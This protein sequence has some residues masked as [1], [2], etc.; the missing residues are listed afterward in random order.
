M[1]NNLIFKNQIN[2]KTDIDFYDKIKIILVILCI[3][4]IPTKDHWFR[5]YMLVNTIL[6]CLLLVKRSQIANIKQFK[7][8]IYWLFAFFIFVSI[9]TLILPFNYDYERELTEVFRILIII[10]LLIADKKYFGNFGKNIFYYIAIVYII[11][12]TILTLSE[13][14]IIP[15]NSFYN[16]IKVYYHIEVQS[17]L[18]YLAKG[19]SSHGAIHAVIMSFFAI[20][21]VCHLQSKKYPLID[22]FLI[23]LCLYNVLAAGSRTCMVGIFIFFIFY[24]II[25]IFTRKQKTSFYF[26]LILIII[27]CSFSFIVSSGDFVK[28]QYLVEKGTNVSSFV[29]RQDNWIEFIDLTVEYWYLIFIG[30]GKTIFLKNDYFYTDNDYFTYFLIHGLIIFAVLI[31]CMLNLLIQTIRDWSYSN[32]Y[33]STLFYFLVFLFIVSTSSA[34][35]SLPISIILIVLFYRFKNEKTNFDNR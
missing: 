15:Y 22:F 19:F 3:F 30:W 10:P 21:M 17:N 20:F 26:Y 9:K 16:L 31:Y 29:A 11:L 27:F 35:F 23:L 6:P 34:G 18:S 2:P 32:I 5:I 25:S 24:F 8:I 12:D 33:N 13:V 7:Y 14:K 1:I 28:L 4:F